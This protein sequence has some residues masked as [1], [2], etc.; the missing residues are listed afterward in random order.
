[1]TTLSLL[2][3]F[4]AKVLPRLAGI[5]AAWV[6]GE[7]Q[8]RFHLTLD[9]VEVTALM[10]GA[11]AVVHRWVSE[12]TNPGDATKTVLIAEDKAA[13]AAPP[14]AGVAAPAAAA[15]PDTDEDTP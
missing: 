2:D 3:R 5:V 7:A 9:P 11:Y 4:A 8:R 12:H 10:L 15:Q 13:V 14:A 6:V 1:M